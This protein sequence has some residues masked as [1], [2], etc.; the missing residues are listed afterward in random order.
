LLAL[1]PCSVLADEKPADDK[2]TAE[3]STAEKPQTGV[4]PAG[5]Q[6]SDEPKTL[7]FGKQT[8]SSLIDKIQSDSYA[9]RE[10]AYQLLLS[11][12]DE[13]I[14]PIEESLPKVD[15]DAATRLIRLLGAW[16]TRPDSGNGIQA[17]ESLQR[18]SSGGVTSNSQL[19]R[20]H[21]SAIAL[22][23]SEVAAKK[24]NAMS[25]FIGTEMVQVVTAAKYDLCI[26]RIDDNFRG[27]ANEL[28]SAR[29]LL[30]PVLVRL[31]GKRIDREWLEK[32]IDMPNV[33]TVQLK[34]TSLTA[35]DIQLLRNMKTLDT[36]EILYMPLDDTAIESIGSL[37]I[38]GSLRI[39]GTNISPSALPKLESLLEGTQVVFGLGGFL[40]IQSNAMTLEVSQV[41][42][43]SGADKGGMMVGDRILSIDGKLLQNFEELRKELGKSPAG[44]LVTIEVRRYKREIVDGRM[45]VVPV[46][47]KLPITLGEQ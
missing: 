20:Y 30:D 41:T 15:H 28:R 29:W 13:A 34:H 21:S 36:L 32:I 2:P 37:P 44:G 9:S 18:L 39:F 3:K 45:T 42:P 23:Q 27:T 14:K 19:A 7:G 38:W 11:R 17:W 40:G 16:A 10:I 47:V 43:G 8:V 1:L 35:E 25:A 31:D 46:D 26:L 5:D 12:P 4:D 22:E 24:L 33:K 6:S